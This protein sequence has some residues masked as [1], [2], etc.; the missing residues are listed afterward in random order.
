ML[1]MND[2]KDDEL[3]F[4]SHPTIYFNTRDVKGMLLMLNNVKG[5]IH[6]IEVLS[7]IHLTVRKY[8]RVQL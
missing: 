5:T 8:S 3:S 1:P 2:I 7:H 6:N 4:V